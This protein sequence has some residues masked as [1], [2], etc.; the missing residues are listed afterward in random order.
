[1]TRTLRAL[2]LTG[3][4]GIGIY[5]LGFVLYLAGALPRLGAGATGLIATVF[6][7]AGVLRI[8]AWI[9]T[10]FA[11]VAGV[12]GA[13]ASV[14]RR[15][16]W[17]AVALIGVLS[18]Q[19]LYSLL[20]NFF[21]PLAWPFFPA[22]LSVALYGPLLGVVVTTPIAVLVLAYSVLPSLPPANTAHPGIKGTRE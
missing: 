22:G 2:A 20:L 21:P 7:V 19:Q 6:L 5:W 8:A 17:W 11:Y 15:Q 9:G 4:L 16:R 14:Q 3:F 12:V 18:L 13:V 1:L 10:V